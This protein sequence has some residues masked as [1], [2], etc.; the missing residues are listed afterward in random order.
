MSNSGKKQ[1]V[2]PVIVAVERKKTPRQSTIQKYFMRKQMKDYEDYE[3]V[4]VANQTLG[5]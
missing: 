3:R 2:K 5:F 1:K 4:T